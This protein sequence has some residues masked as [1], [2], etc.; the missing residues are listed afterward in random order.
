VPATG[1]RRWGRPA[2]SSTARCVPSPDLYSKRNLP[3]KRKS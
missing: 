1:S 3:T 2:R